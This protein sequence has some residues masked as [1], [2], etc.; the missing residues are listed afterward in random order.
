MIFLKGKRPIMGRGLMLEEP[1]EKF[2]PFG[3]FV[4]NYPSLEDGY[5][6][7]KYP[8]SG[9]IPHDIFKRKMRISSTL[10]D[11]M[12]DLL[13]KKKMSVGKYNK[14]NED[15]KQIFKNLSKL[16]KL[17]RLLGIDE[18]SGEGINIKNNNDNDDD[19]KRFQILIGQIKAGND[20]KDL[21]RQLILLLSKFILEGRIEK[22]QGEEIIKELID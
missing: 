16:S 9:T 21:K 15:E 4:I 19:E 2:V 6:Q 8:S 13:E 22:Q 10:K 7:I 5:L 14:L 12:L 20:N 18:E 11:F 1:K 3:K 17:N